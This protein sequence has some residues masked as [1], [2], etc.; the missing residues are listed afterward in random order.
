M[1]EIRVVL[2]EDH[3]LTRIG[4][5]ATLQQSG[6]VN[7]VGEAVDGVQG[8]KLLEEIKPD[9]ALVDIGLPLMDGIALTR[10][11]QQNLITTKNAE[12]SST[13]FLILT[14]Q[15]SEEAVLAAFAAGADS[16]CMKDSKTATLLEALQSTYEG[17]N[18]ID[19]AIAQIILHHNRS[20]QPVQDDKMNS[21][22][23]RVAIA[24]LSTED[25]NLLENYPLTERENDVLNLIVEGCS[26]AQI[27]EKLY[28]TVGTVKTHVRNILNKMAVDD[29]TQIA[30]RTL[31]AGLVQ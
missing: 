9:I 21:K 24:G 1:N 12:Q 10:S 18:W 2:I 16:Y 31:R 29:R 6:T 27:A 26:N 5:R 20:L 7:I 15:D 17:N 3:D 30:V 11:F 28:I 22:S 25:S 23:R 8:L 4:L 14:M 13:K 19:P